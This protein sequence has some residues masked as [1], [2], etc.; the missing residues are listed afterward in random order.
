[1]DK[2][3]FAFLS[4]TGYVNLQFTQGFSTAD[5]SIIYG[6]GMTVTMSPLPH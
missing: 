4:E 2:F 6:R 3:T 5:K 1:M